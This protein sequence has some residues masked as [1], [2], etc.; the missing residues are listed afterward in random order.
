MFKGSWA[1]LVT[2]Y[3][4]DYS[5]DQEALKK[6]VE[7]HIFEGTTGLVVGGSTGEGILLQPDEHK[8]LLKICLEAAQ[9]RIQIVASVSAIRLEDSL[10][11][12]RQ[13]QELGASGLMLAP[14]PYVKPTQD[15]IINFVTNVHDQTN[16][17][18]I[19]YNNPGRSSVTMN[20]DTIIKLA[21]L[22]RVVCLKDATGQLTEISILKAHLPKNFTHLCGEDAFNVASLAEGNNGWISVTANVAPRLCAQLYQAWCQ[23]DL[24]TFAYIRDLLN[25]LHRAIFV[26]TSPSPI[27]YALAR[28]GFCRDDVRLPLLKA[29]SVARKAVD[30]ALDF[31]NQ[32][33]KTFSLKS[34]ST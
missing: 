17:P 3:H 18:I 9:D 25:P 6:L 32:S 7:W 16:L 33:Q 26:E 5:I 15:A 20:F 19:I 2:P 21:R 10:Y 4:Q 1:A 29:T 13:A 12:A 34:L 31:M 8:F 24:G 28:Q 30:Q 22:S 23:Q 11:L 14:S 27:K